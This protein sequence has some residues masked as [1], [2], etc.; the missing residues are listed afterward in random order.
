MHPQEPPDCLVLPEHPLI[1]LLQIR[2]PKLTNEYRVKAR[3]EGVSAA[4]PDAVYDVWDAFFLPYT[5]F[6]GV[7]R[8]GPNLL[9]ACRN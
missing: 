2:V 6:T 8:P 3:F 9:V 5:G 4:S 1:D 7:T